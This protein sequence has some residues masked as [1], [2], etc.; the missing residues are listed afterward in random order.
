MTVATWNPADK[1]ANIALSNG[2]LTATG[3]VSSAWKSVRATSGKDAGQ[4]Y[5]E[6]L[7]DVAPDHQVGIADAGVPL[8]SFI[9]ND[10]GGY[11]YNASGHKLSAGSSVSYGASYGVGDRISV[12]LDLDSGTLEFWENGA[13]TAWPIRG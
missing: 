2:D 13:T 4:W 5:W 7:I 9:G 1:H 3:T 12:L 10:A 6:I 11:G 8:S